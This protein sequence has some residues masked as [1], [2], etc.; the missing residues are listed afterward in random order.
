MSTAIDRLR[1][2]ERGGRRLQID[3]NGPRAAALIRSWPRLTQAAHGAWQA[4]PNADPG[5]G[6][7]VERI[8][9]A[10]TKLDH[11]ADRRPWPGPV[12][13]DGGLD[14]VTASLVAAAR[15]ARAENT[16]P[17]DAAECQRLI[18][19]T[20]WTTARA[21][22]D[23]TREHNFDVRYDKT[24]TAERDAICR[25]TVDVCR[26]LGVAEQLA[27]GRL[28]RHPAPAGGE[29]AA[30]SLGQAI[31]RWDI[32]AHRALVDLPTT[33]SLHV[34]SYF[35][36]DFSDR[37]KPFLAAAA[38]EGII[39]P[40]THDRLSPVLQ[41]GHRAWR[42][43]L[44]VASEF[45]FATVQVPTKLHDAGVDLHDRLVLAPPTSSEGHREV[46]SALSEHLASSLGVAQLGRDLI[47]DRELRAPAR[48]VA[49]VVS[50]HHPELTRAVVTAEQIRRGV[51]VELPDE[52]RRILQGPMSRAVE[53]G[54]EAVSRS[55]ALDTLYRRPAVAVD[56]SRPPAHVAQPPGLGSPPHVGSPAR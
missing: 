45:S 16:A 47:D 17:R 3:A 46:L 7:V 36:A 55:A 14:Q 37:M 6:L 21:I 12:E 5:A 2:A 8:A 4:I 11:P 1:A 32:E 39:D 19:S 13:T 33:A 9:R 48:A 43:V 18:L 49:R 27:A 25:S 26:R 54:S 44:D 15:T 41:A 56:G 50:E 42:D 51:T 30:I 52:A 29:S 31:A 53:S 24:L 40:S 20:L 23:A 22:G 34:V 35:Q 10:A 38:T 28:F